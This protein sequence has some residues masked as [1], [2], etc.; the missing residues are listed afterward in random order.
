MAQITPATDLYALG[1]VLYRMLAGRPP[2]IGDGVP[3]QHISD[4]PLPLIAF[5]PHIP[6]GLDSLTLQLLEKRPGDRPPDAGAVRA[7]LEPYLPR[8][9]EVAPSP[10]FDPDPTAV[11]RAPRSHPQPVAARASAVFQEP[12]RRSPWLRR[13]E[14]EAMLARV[15]AQL[16]SG[17][18]DEVSH[19]ELQSL[20]ETARSQ[21]GP[22]DPLVLSGAF[23]PE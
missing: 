1:C 23:L 13:R 16:R 2:F 5:G 9:G 8:L 17:D 10:R 15:Q 12:R 4:R 7:L 6:A 3:A 20:H 21:W 19:I 22:A 11:F 18:N 14:V